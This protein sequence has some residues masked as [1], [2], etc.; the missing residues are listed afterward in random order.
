[1]KQYL[2]ALQHVFLNGVEKEDRTGT[3]TRSVFGY[4][5]RFDLR[6]GFPLV[7]TKKLFIK[8][9]IHELLWF[10]KG[11]TNIQY[12][13]DNGVHIWDEWASTGEERMEYHLGWAERAELAVRNKLIRVSL[14][15]LISELNRMEPEDRNKYLDD[16]GVPK[17]ENCCYPSVVPARFVVGTK[18]QT[19]RNTFA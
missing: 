3:G 2:D 18:Y 9:I 10:L 11:E 6:D 4:Q 16:L 15:G 12:L 7:T 1:M 19:H 17:E 14:S 13:L 5:M 8:G